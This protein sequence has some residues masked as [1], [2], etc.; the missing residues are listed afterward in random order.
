MREAEKYQNGPVPEIER[1]GDQADEDQRLQ[2]QDARNFRHVTFA[3]MDEQGCSQDWKQGGRSRKK[4]LIVISKE[5][6]ANQQQR[7]H[8]RDFTVPLGLE[9]RDATKRQKYAETQF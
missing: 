5:G 6:G 4:G 7:C 3:R 8:A 9:V 1:I 2:P